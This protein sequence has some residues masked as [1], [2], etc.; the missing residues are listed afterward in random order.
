V[1][2]PNIKNNYAM[3][4]NGEKWDLINR[5]N[6]IDDMYDDS[7]NILIEKMEELESSNLDERIKRKFRR[8]IDR[9]E[10]DEVRNKIKEDIK[11]LLYNNKKVIKKIK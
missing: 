6:I 9:K 8:F 1:Y 5:K 2:I 10:D 7:S 4:W 3:I 11:L